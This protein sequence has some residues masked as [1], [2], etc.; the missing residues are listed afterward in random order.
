MD[1]SASKDPQT[2]LNKVGFAVTTEFEVVKVL[3]NCHQIIR[4]RQLN[5]LL[6]TEACKTYGRQMC[7]NLHRLALCFRGHARFLGHFGSTDIFL[8]SDGTSD[9]K[10]IP[11]V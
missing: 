3:A 10:R 5:W 6:L 8:K 1:G 7:D 9:I 4:L 11:C 2:G